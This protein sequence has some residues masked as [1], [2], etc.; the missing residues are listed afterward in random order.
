MITY[1]LT[2]TENRNFGCFFAHDANSEWTEKYNLVQYAM[3]IQHFELEEEYLNE[4]NDSDIIKFDPISDKYLV[5]IDSENCAEFYGPNN[6]KN[7]NLFATLLIELRSLENINSFLYL[8]IDIIE[9]DVKFSKKIENKIEAIKKL[10][11]DQL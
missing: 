2:P 3:N 1:D 5:E 11:D 6:H 7:I 10:L 9:S 8:V 4:I